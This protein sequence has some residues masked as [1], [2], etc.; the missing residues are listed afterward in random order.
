MPPSKCALG[1]VVFALVSA[2]TQPTGLGDLTLEA[3]VSS[4]SIALGQTD[5]LRYRLRNLTTRSISLTF[6]SACQFAPFIEKANDGVAYPVG[7]Q[8]C[9]TVITH[10][11]LP[12]S[13]EHTFTLIVLGDTVP[14][15]FAG[16]VLPPGS[17]QGYA[18]VQPSSPSLR[19]R[20]G[21]VGFEIH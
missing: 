3:S 5:T 19:L 11:T 16:A 6:A 9:A 13:G 14:A 15:M 2:C 18:V 10:L 17:Y 1:L 4:P 21:A 8:V 12:P 20:S 7:G